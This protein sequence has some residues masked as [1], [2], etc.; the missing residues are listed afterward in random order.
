[1]EFLTTGML[2]HSNYSSFLFCN[3]IITSLCDFGKVMAHCSL[4]R[5]IIFSRHIGVLR[6]MPESWWVSVLSQ[7]QRVLFILYQHTYIKQT[8]KGR[9][10]RQ[11]HA[12]NLLSGSSQR[13]TVDFCQRGA[14][15]WMAGGLALRTLNEE[16][17]CLLIDP[18]TS[19]DLM[20][21]WV[22]A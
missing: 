14:G 6:W 16:S 12:K 13:Q 4:Q 10:K 11:R 8:D 5:F 17:V 2:F 7:V 18:A 1:M 19:A 3:F 21:G 20:P 22:T 15:E 9:E